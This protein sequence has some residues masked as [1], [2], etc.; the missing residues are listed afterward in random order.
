MARK[1]YSG[2]GSGIYIIS[3]SANDKSYIG[4]SKTVWRRMSDHYKS[5]YFGKH[6]NRYLQAAFDK[7]GEVS[8]TYSIYKTCVT[9]ELAQEEKSAIYAYGRK[10]LF[11][12]TDGGEGASGFVRSQ[13]QKDN[14]RT[15]ARK[16]WAD[17]SCDTLNMGIKRINIFSGN[18][19]M[20]IRT[21][22]VSADGFVQDCVHACI[23]GDRATYSGFFWLRFDDTISYEIL[24]SRLHKANFYQALK[25]RSFALKL[26]NVNMS[27]EYYP[28][29]IHKVRLTTLSRK[30]KPVERTDIKS[31]IVKEYFSLQDACR[32]GFDRSTLQKSIK[33]RSSYR[34]YY[35]R[36]ISR[37]PASLEY[38]DSDEGTNAKNKYYNSVSLRKS[39]RE[40]AKLERLESIKANKLIIKRNKEMLKLETKAN[41]VRCPPHN[42]GIAATDQQKE[43]LRQKNLGKRYSDEVNLSKGRCGRIVSEETREKLSISNTGK[44]GYRHPKKCKPVES[45][46][47]I[48]GIKK[49]YSSVMEAARDGFDR[50]GLKRALNGVYSQ[51]K[52]Y[53]W[54]YV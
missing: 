1:L 11:N 52:G 53:T 2:D 23:R 3:C 32:D 5:L 48:S 35:W 14:C 20:Y 33:S 12:F 39:S 25:Y 4:M 15:R 26:D 30:Y 51:A 36:H 19:T 13:V 34:G 47:I 29:P 42:K 46:N 38:V 6:K 24:Y 10:N 21:G 45:T 43:N 17:N 18:I 16:M 41:R 31:G 9:S 49:R 8:L 37:G 50:A 40:A 28:K 54:K 7:Y 27:D 22:L 44:P